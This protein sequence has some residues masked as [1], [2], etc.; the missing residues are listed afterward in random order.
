MAVVR[1]KKIA[2]GVATLDVESGGGMPEGALV[3]L[4][5]SPGSGHYEFAY[6][7]AIMTAVSKA[8]SGESDKADM[9][10]PSEVCY[11]SF[12]RT[13]EDIVS[14]LYY[15][16]S[17]DLCS[18]FEEQV[19]FKDMSEMFFSHPKIAIDEGKAGG[20]DVLKETIKILEERPKNS[21]IILH[22]LSDLAKI[23]Q[24]ENVEKYTLYLME[25]RKAIRKSKSLAYG[26]L[27]KGALTEHMQNNVIDVSDG[28]LS[29]GWRE[30]GSSERKRVMYID[31]FRG[32][33]T[34]MAEGVP[35]FDV[36]VSPQTGFA[37]SKVTKITRV[38]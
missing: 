9:V 37:I 31:K 16:H 11:I 4:L 14:E 32:L 8:T 34:H 19:T 30:A 25:L 36:G 15:G 6:T 1:A 20:P 5:G 27:D 29:Y 18:I 12:G 13:K 22:S 35:I 10:K 33:M 23:F 24:G 26:L 7:S 3:T 2:T 28:V 21:L 17:A 38:G